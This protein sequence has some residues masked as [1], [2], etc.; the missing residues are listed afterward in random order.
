VSA[1]LVA[2][3]VL[4]SGAPTPLR[5]VDP[6]SARAGLEARDRALVRR[7]VGI[8]IRRRATLRAL[9]R[10]FAR[11]KPNPDLV[12]HLHL[13]LTQLFFLDR[14]PDHAAIHETSAAV[15][16]T[17]GPSKVRY[18]N[19]ILR[20]ALRARVAGQVGDPTRDL[21]GR[22]LSLQEPVFHDPQEHPFLWAEDALSLPAPLAKRWTKRYGRERMEELARLALDEA[23]LS[24]R[25]AADDVSAVRVELASTGLDPR[26]T[27]HER[28]FLLASQDV[29][30]LGATDA[31]RRG[32]VTVQGESALRAAEL[33][34]ARAGERILDLC[35]APGGKTAVLA[36]SGAD[37]VALDKSPGRLARLRETI[38]RLGVAERV[39]VI[40]ADGAQGLA[41]TFDAVLVD[42]PC[43]NTGVLAQRP[44]ARWRFGP[45]A[46]R[47]LALVQT[48]LV[49]EA[50]ERVRPGGRLVWS[51]CTL[52]PEENRQ[53]VRAFLERHP[54]WTSE[55]EIE[56]LPA[57]GGPIDGGYAARLTRP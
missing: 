37:V 49:D 23:P 9:V 27:E 29:E 39:D 2:W 13:G 12:A 21:V 36:A 35:A 57:A 11:G 16:T 6:F 33:C 44:E 5:L 22:D 52:E 31:F 55:H 10:A 8:E 15:H 45:A 3:E 30:A 34:G 48:R 43:S 24:I 20:S 4:R 46:Q 38:E 51:T 50:A 17:S 56:A 47:E 41:G 40:A 32:A 26:A 14:I 53:R 28:V 54:G 42:A 18:V 7:L 1:R 25:V 19:A